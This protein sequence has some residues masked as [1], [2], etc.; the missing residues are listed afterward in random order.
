MTKF[1][2]TCDPAAVLTLL[3]M[4]HIVHRGQSPLPTPV[5]QRRGGEGREGAY[6]LFNRAQVLS[7]LSYP[8]RRCVNRTKK[9]FSTIL[10][11]RS[12]N[13]R[14]PQL[15]RSYVNCTSLRNVETHQNTRHACPPTLR[16]NCGCYYSADSTIMC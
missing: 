16:C 8:P 9:P 13:S 6:T 10:T 1:I 11:R 4:H 5:T 15:H 2:F 7:Q 14:G 12:V 3:S